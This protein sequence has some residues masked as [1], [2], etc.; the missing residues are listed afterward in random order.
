LVVKTLGDGGFG[1]V[2]LGLRMPMLMEVA[3]KVLHPL[4]DQALLSAILQ[5]F[6]GEARALA[7]VNHPNVVRLIDFGEQDLSPF[8]VMEYVPGARTLRK[9]IDEL[10]MVG[11]WFAAEEVYE[12][13][14]QTADGLAAVHS[15]GVLHRDVKP[16]NLML[17][18]V[19]G[20]P[21][22]VRIVDFGLAKFTERGD[23]TSSAMGTPAYMAPEQL[24]QR[25]LGPWTD[26]YALG[27]VAFELL[28]G[29]R[30]F[31]GRTSQEIIAQKLDPAYDPLRGIFDLGLPDATAAFLRRSLARDPEKRFR[32]GPSFRS[33][34]REATEAMASRACA[35]T[36]RGATSG[37]A[38]ES[39]P[40]S[41]A[42]VEGP[43]VERAS[44]GGSSLYWLGG[45]VILAGGIALLCWLALR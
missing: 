40:S 3:V 13:L 30:A 33:A 34:A 21:M 4:E 20:N 23:S 22:L 19:E 1:K 26:L 11:R 10:A 37:D 7:V 18:S 44:R 28:T 25:G 15:S 12:I 45:V 9:Q 14:R 38:R 17:Q 41:P 6:E 36:N 5:K 8:M 27:V 31:T 42:V 2:Y 29:R 39:A 43:L 35:A 16:E 24:M 32:D